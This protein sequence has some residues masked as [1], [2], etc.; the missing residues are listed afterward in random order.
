[1]VLFR[2][3]GIKDHG[4]NCNRRATAGFSQNAPYFFLGKMP[5]SVRCTIDLITFKKFWKIEEYYVECAC[6]LEDE[7]RFQ[8]CLKLCHN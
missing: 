3:A 8:K 7:S 1:M 2:L 5:K 6:H 4:H